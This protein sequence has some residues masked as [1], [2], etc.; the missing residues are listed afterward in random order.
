[1][2]L[3]AIYIDHKNCPYWPLLPFEMTQLCLWSMF[4][5]KSIS[6]L[7]LYLTLTSF[8]EKTSRT[9]ASLSPE[10]KCVISVGRLGFGHVQVP[11]RGFKSQ[12]EVCSF[13]KRGGRQR[14][15]PNHFLCTLYKSKHYTTWPHL[16]LNSSWN[17]Y[18]FYVGKKTVSETLYNFPKVTQF[19]EKVGVIK[20]VIWLKSSCS[21]HYRMFL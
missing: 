12:S 18:S 19:L 20:Q 21:F 10:I 5:I 15:F 7:S 4:L 1:M 9:W 13:T 6:Y 8:W 17:Y 3:L 11:A 16:I 2:C 14:T